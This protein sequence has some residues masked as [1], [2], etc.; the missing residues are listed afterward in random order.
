MWEYRG[1]SLEELKMHPTVKPVQMIA[2]VM[3]DCS[4][5]GH[6]VLDLFGGSGS[7]IIAAQ[8]AGR[9]AY[10]SEFDPHYCDLTL[11]RWGGCQR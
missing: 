2:D 1:A 9:I 3:K 4:G 5:R 7:T 8:K 10:L 6:I 11:N